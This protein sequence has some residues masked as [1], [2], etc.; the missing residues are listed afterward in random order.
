MS[1]LEIRGVTRT[2]PGVRGGQPVLAL[3]PTDLTLEEND[4]VTI[5][6]PSGCGKSTLLRMVAGLE[7][8]T[9]GTIAIDGKVVND[10]E[11]RARDIAMVFQNY[12]LYPHMSVRDNI[13]YPL[14]VRGLSKVDIAGQVAVDES[15]QVL[16]GGLLDGRV[17]RQPVVVLG[18]PLVDVDRQSE[19]VGHRLGGLPGAPLRAADQ[20]G[21]RES[22]QR[23]G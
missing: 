3:Q 23:V 21:D 18:D 22:L 19:R 16:P 15:L 12:A 6:G 1:L 13:G 8:I 5:L 10:L 17:V 2:F 14:K 11:P 20:P 4:F 9:S 7:E